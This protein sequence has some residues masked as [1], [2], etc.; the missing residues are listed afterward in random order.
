MQNREELRQKGYN[1]NRE[2]T[3]HERGKILFSEKGGGI[4]CQDQSIDPCHNHC[5]T[6]G[7]CSLVVEQS[8]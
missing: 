5:M 2:T 7:I 1:G 6:S 8:S 4:V 3:R